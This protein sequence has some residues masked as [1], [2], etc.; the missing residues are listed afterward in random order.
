MQINNQFKTRDS[1]N[2]PIPNALARSNIL[3][4]SETPLLIDV[5]SSAPHDA[6]KSLHSNIIFKTNFYNF[7]ICMY[8][9]E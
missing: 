6:A 7:F 4:V 2:N 1:S 3:L 5:A 9:L 8:I